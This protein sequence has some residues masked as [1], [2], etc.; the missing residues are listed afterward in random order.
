MTTIPER[1]NASSDDIPDRIWEE[2]RQLR[3]V[4]N[5]TSNASVEAIAMFLL[6]AEKRGREEERERCAKFCEEHEVGTS[7]REGQIV[8]R[9]PH[10]RLYLHAGDAYAAAIRSTN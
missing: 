5:W 7:T 1:R 4:V 2:A 3:N 6:A 9:A 10:N 8:T